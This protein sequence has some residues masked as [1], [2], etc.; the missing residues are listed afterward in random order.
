MQLTNFKNG[1]Q[2][3][4]I[5]IQERGFD[6]ELWNMFIEN[7]KDFD[8]MFSEILRDKPKDFIE[9][10]RCYYSGYALMVDTKSY[11]NSSTSWQFSKQRIFKNS[12]IY[13]R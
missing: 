7:P 6:L 1:E 9:G 5:E 10:Y 4:E 12:L 8:T 3:A 2:A 13:L 11:R